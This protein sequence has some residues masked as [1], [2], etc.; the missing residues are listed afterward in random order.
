VHGGDQITVSVG[1]SATAQACNASGA[2]AAGFG[3][4]TRILAMIKPG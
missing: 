2:G 3:T 4:V 1:L